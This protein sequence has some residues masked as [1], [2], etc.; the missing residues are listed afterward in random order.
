VKIVAGT[1]NGVVGPVRDV[2]TG[3]EYLDVRVPAGKTFA[4]AT[5]RGH[6][7]FAYVFAGKGVFDPEHPEPVGDRHLVA[8]GDGDTVSVRATPEP[9]RFLLISGKPI[10]EPIAWRGPIVMN[11]EHEL[12]MAFDELE[13]GT[14]IKNQKR[15]S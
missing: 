4:H 10:G 1:V 2:V 13:R 7:V 14:F 15:R 3:P 9:V 12:Q 6:T 5:P 8:L 11:T